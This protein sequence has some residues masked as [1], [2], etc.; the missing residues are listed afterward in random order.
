MVFLSKYNPSMIQILCVIHRNYSLL[1]LQ[2]EHWKKIK[3]DFELVFLDNTPSNERQS[4]PNMLYLDTP[5]SDGESHG[6]ALDYLVSQATSDIVG[7]VDSDFFWTNENIIS[8]VEELFSQGNICVGASAKYNDWE[9]YMDKCFPE[10]HSSLAPVIWGMFVDRKLAAEQTFVC[11]DHEGRSFRLY[12]GHRLRQR[13]ISENLPRVT[14]Q[15]FYP[16]GKDDSQ[17]VYY[18]EPGKVQGVHFLKGSAAKMGQATAD[19]P[20]ILASLGF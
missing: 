20:R 12:T 8:E 15:G 11:T 4:R 16:N 7:I 13:I 9:E 3:G 2:L 18:G 10:R 14:F 6:A 1:D 19:L 17:G 5:G